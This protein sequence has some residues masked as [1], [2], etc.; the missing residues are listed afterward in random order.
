MDSIY[1]EGI[2]NGYHGVES[3]FTWNLVGCVNNA[4]TP[5]SVYKR[6]QHTKWAMNT[7][8]LL[9][10]LIM[11]LLVVALRPYANLQHKRISRPGARH[12]ER[13]VGSSPVSV[14]QE[15]FTPL[16]NPTLEWMVNSGITSMC[17][18]PTP[19]YLQELVYI[20]GQQ[21]IRY[22]MSLHDPVL[23]H[24]ISK[25]ILAHGA[26]PS[27]SEL[28]HICGHSEQAGTTYSIVCGEGRVFVEVGSAV[29]MVSLYAA[30]RG[31]RV[32]AMD[33]IKPNVDR[34][35]ES[36]C[37]NGVAHCRNHSLGGDSG[38]RNCSDSALW[39]PFA[40]NKLSTTWS[41][42][43]S[44]PGPPRWIESKPQNLAA[45]AGGGGEYRSMVD[46]TSLDA[47]LSPGTEIEIL[48]L[49]CQGFEYEALLGADILLRS[50]KIKSIIWRRHP[51]D[52][53]TQ[54]VQVLGQMRHLSA[55]DTNTAKIVEL[56][57]ECGYDFY[58]IQN[59]R[60]DTGNSPVWIERSQLVDYVLS[61][62]YNGDHPNI[63]SV[64][65]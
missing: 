16:P 11:L 45:T 53:E 60:F 56:L 39:G 15:N 59:S 47:S 10:S 23:D 14:I 1:K 42:V 28:H 58:N 57:I 3:I 26:Y 32:H 7:I 61:P 35:S 33:P 30:A 36:R 24:V 38:D 41:F 5:P 64:L 29:G 43:S 9:A 34:L 6:L 19:H 17:N 46:V 55:S 22:V 13:L 27:I 52:G 21:P 25:G 2:N 18:L 62:L 51:S 54:P 8:Q 4:E 37:L 48:L 12:F 20:S 63:F 50:R 65:R 49:T 31:M 44:S 40:P